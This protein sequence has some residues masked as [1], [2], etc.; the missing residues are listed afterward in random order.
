M[1]NCYILCSCDGSF[2]P[3]LS[4]LDGLSLF[5]GGFVSIIV[6]LPKPIQTCFY[7]QNLGELDCEIVYSITIDPDVVCDCDTFCYF[8]QFDEEPKQTIYVNSGND[9]VVESFPTGQ[10]V[11]FCSR[12]YPIFDSI[13]NTPVQ[14]V[15]SCVGN[16]C[17]TT[18]PSIARSNECDVITIFPM[19]VECIVNNP[20]N[21]QT[22]DG[23]AQLYIT[24][25]TPPYTIFWEVGSYAPALT[26]LGVG[27][28][29][30]T[31]SDFY[32]DFVIDTTCVLEAET[33][34][35]SAMCFEIR[36]KGIQGT[37]YVTSQ[38]AGIQNTK[39]FYYLSLG[40]LSI[41]IVFWDGLSQTWVFCLTLACNSNQY[42][43]YLNNSGDYP[44][45][46]TLN[47][48]SAGTSTN[49]TILNS[50]I[51]ECNPPVPVVTYGNLCANI[52]IDSKDPDKPFTQIQVQ[53]IYDGNVNGQP[54]WQ[55]VDEQYY[56]YWNTG[57]TPNQ[58]VVTGVTNSN[59]TS[60]VN[61]YPTAPP[62][63][64]WQI[65]GNGIVEGFTI[66]SGNCVSATTV[67]FTVSKN[68][69]S[70][71]NSGSIMI[72]AYG[73]IAPFQYSIDNGTTYSNVPYFQNLSPGSYNVL[74]VDSNNNVG[75][76]IITLLGGPVTIYQLGFAITNNGNFSVVAPFLPS[77][78]TISFDIVQTSTLSYY[79]NNLSPIPQ[80]NN[81]VSIVGYSG[82][83]LYNT[84]TNFS[85]VTG[86]CTL[87]TP[88]IIKNQITNTYKSNFILSSGQSLSGTTTNQVLFPPTGQ[89]QGAQGTFQIQ[90]A[91]VKM[92][93]CDCC[94]VEIVNF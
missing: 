40:L 46:S 64:N 50:T 18:L 62:L 20:T 56:I 94:E 63:S 75:Q 69:A 85:L 49:Y 2:E 31:V 88:I 71:N 37:Q 16:N 60:I 5:Q 24:G 93:G 58:W 9:V 48:W 57:S 84:A 43:Q 55:S 82:L 51:G 7:V 44:I 86:P 73:G 83:S 1:E 29:N 80:Y 52:V 26:N 45:S 65:L 4:N 59:T 19:G 92:N 89:C 72:N 32:G 41:G 91:N 30:A 6:N 27:T 8:V 13:G 15:N 10:T 54:T 21:S 53:L 78:V 70:C 81:T 22:F 12:I 87:T 68:D 39:P 17:P 14:I 25:G 61:N 3:I 79:P 74:V 77:G 33:L 34:T 36:G 11:N 42:Y 23:S 66:V 35:Y 28:Y 47:Q 90:L 38:F 76:Q 67:N